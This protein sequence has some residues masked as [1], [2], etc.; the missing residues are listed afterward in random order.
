MNKKKN[1]IKDYRIDNAKH[2]ILGIDRLLTYF[3]EHLDMPSAMCDPY[4]N[5]VM[6]KRFTALERSLRYVIT[7]ILEDTFP[8][9]AAAFNIQRIVFSSIVKP[10]ERYCDKCDRYYQIRYTKCDACHRNY[11][12]K[13][14][15]CNGKG[16]TQK[17]H[18]NYGYVSRI[19][20]EIRGE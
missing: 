3:Y 4:K 1:K 6:R 8:E 12:R 2:H 13:C 18:S 16:M 7:A 5:R 15:F 9:T 10:D 19:L 11:E 14:T 17:P 20:K